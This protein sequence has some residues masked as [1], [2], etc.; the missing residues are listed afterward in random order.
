MKRIN[1]SAEKI[2]SQ[3]KREGIKPTSR[4]RFVVKDSFFW[5]AFTLSVVVGAMAVSIILNTLLNNDWD[6]Y[7]E[8]SGNLVQFIVITLPYFWLILLGGLIGVAY[9]NI[10]HTEKAY[11]FN[12]K[13]IVGGAVLSSCLLGL[14]FYNLGLASSFDRQLIQKLPMRFHK[15]VNPQLRVWQK[16]AEGFLIGEIQDFDENCLD[17]RDFE[18]NLWKISLTLELKESFSPILLRSD[19]KKV[20]IIGQLDLEKCENCFSATVIRL[21]SPRKGMM[22][23]YV[24]K[25]PKEDTPEMMRTKLK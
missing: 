2:I 6:I 11:R 21:L 23:E 19:S 20:K 3:I 16:P 18:G 8:L 17:V 7:M 25:I 15:M 4:W 10:K 14:T 22:K 1:K 12:L 24:D 5:V 13:V 9:L